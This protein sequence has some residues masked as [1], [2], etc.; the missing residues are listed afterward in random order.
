MAE[1]LFYQIERQPLE[2]ALT[3]LLSRTLERGQRAVVQVGSPERLAALD[4][5]LWTFAE[6]SF[7]PHGT[8]ADGDAELQPVLLTEGEEN[9]NG[10]TVRFY[11]DGAALA[12]LEHY[13]RSV[14]LFDGRL[15]D[16][17][18]TARQRWRQV[19]QAGVEATYWRQTEA[20]RWER[21]G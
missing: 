13:E 6:D 1:V 20:G 10:A 17:L 15:A 16:E 14:Y 2:R 11:V 21:Q 18:E 4:S 3:T 5:H 19:R 9:P 7:L 8:L 12:S